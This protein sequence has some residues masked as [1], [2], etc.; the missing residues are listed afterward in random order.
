LWEKHM[1]NT[2][3][4]RQDK[5]LAWLKNENLIRIDELANRLT[6]S[7]M[8][9]HRDLTQ[10]ARQGL[11][12][13]VHGGVQLPDPHSVMVEV[14]ALCHMPVQQRLQFMLTTKAN[15][16]VRACCAHCGLLLLTQRDDIDAALLREFI[17]GRII[18]A[19]HAYFVIG[20]RISL[21]CE[22]SV[23]AFS[24][25]ADAADFQQGFGGRLMDFDEARRQLA[26]DHAIC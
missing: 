5:I 22:P 13:K 17:Y 20:S 12:E 26:L 16:Q 24:S 18:N 9:V 14:C 6:V 8:T 2:P 3:A 23:L 15:E 19:L 1:S 4:E 25:R 11:V 7:A 10:L 21:C